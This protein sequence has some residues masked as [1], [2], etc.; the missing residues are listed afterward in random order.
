MENKIIFTK[1][2]N[3]HETDILELKQNNIIVVQVEDLSQL[4]TVN[5]IENDIILETA[6]QTIKESVGSQKSVFFDKFFTKY[7]KQK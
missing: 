7:F 1:K 4:K 6:M 2:G 3:I 5:E